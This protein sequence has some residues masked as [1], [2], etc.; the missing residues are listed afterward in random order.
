VLVVTRRDFFQLQA[1]LR[2]KATEPW[3]LVGFACICRLMLR[4]TEEAE[5]S[6]ALAF[7]LGHGLQNLIGLF[8]ESLTDGGLELILKRLEMKSRIVSFA[9]TL[10]VGKMLGFPS[11]SRVL[12]STCPPFPY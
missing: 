4:P 8:P 9:D 2:T 11:T 7:H 5:V 10:N 3:R 1:G 12:D 6:F